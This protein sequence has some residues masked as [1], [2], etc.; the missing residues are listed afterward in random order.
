M[1]LFIVMFLSMP[2]FAACT[3]TPKASEAERPAVGIQQEAN[4]APAAMA[5]RAPPKPGERISPVIAF[6]GL[7]EHWNIE[8]ENEEDYR[9]SVDFIWGSGSHHASGTLHYEPQSSDAASGRLVLS[10]ILATDAGA[11]TMRVEI[12]PMPCTDDADQAHD[13]SVQITVE[14]MSQMQGC[15]DLAL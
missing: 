5:K 15:G 8:I 14:G 6:R 4:T 3:A 13:H 9:H 7:A 1:R 2:A 10:G 11:R 12:T